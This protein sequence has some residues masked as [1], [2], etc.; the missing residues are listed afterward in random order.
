MKRLPF[1]P[2]A[3]APWRIY[4]SRRIAWPQDKQ[5]LA[6]PAIIVFYRIILGKAA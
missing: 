6:R 4:N 5:A 3:H 2:A 1:H